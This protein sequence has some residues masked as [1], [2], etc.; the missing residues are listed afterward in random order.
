MK[1]C[2]II[3]YN[4]EL[5]IMRLTG[6]IFFRTGLYAFFLSSCF[7]ANAQ[8]VKEKFDILH[9]SE[10]FDSS[11]SYWTT[12]ANAENLF[13]VQ[14]G[15]YIL[16]RKTLVSPFAIIADFNNE[17][18]AFRL[19]TSLKLEKS[20]NDEG[21]IGFI[22]MAQTDG[23]GG[24]IFEINKL[25]QYRVRQIA[26]STYNYITGEAKTG[27]WV[28]SKFINETYSYNLVEVKT[29]NRNYDIYL[30]NNFLLSFSEIAYKSGRM[31]IVIG[32]GT[33]GKVDFIYLFSSSKE[34]TETS[35]DSATTASAFPKETAPD[36]IALAESIIL[37]KTQ[38]NK[39]NEQNEDLRK[40]IEALKSDDEDVENQKKN[41]EKTIKELQARNTKSLASYDSLQKVNQELMKYKEMVAGNENS[42][43]IISLS[44]T[45]KSEKAANELLRQQNKEL[46]D[47]LSAL[48]KSQ[49]TAKSIE[50]PEN[51]AAKTEQPSGNKNFVLPKEGN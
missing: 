30:N 24:F 2:E 17:L 11:S 26:G 46:T 8:L 48:M 16:N 29:F 39:Q 25:K 32:P 45:L 41:Y 19:V 27:G 34:T 49:K 42:D 28:N 38:I 33:K 50:L 51:K 35:N 9:I 36:I 5:Q 18:T 3:F 21:S 7:V 10:N 31:G 40:T 12:L 1:R 6:K 13:I 22:F 23:S 15:E 44:K 20:I 47:S 37:L 4:F 43:L 14:E